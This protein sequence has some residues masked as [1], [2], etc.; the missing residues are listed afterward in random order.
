MCGIVGYIGKRKAWP[1]LFKGLER[2]EYR[3]YDSAG[4]ALLQNGAFSVYKKKGRVVEL[5]K[6][7]KNQ[8]QLSGG[9]GI[10][11]TRWATHGVPSDRNAH[12]HLSSGGDIVIVHNG[13]IENYLS[14]KKILVGKGYRFKSDTDTEVLA[15]LIE[16]IKKH[17]KV[18]IDEVVRLALAQVSGAYAILVLSK[19]EP[20]TMV[21]AK[22][23][24][25]VVIGIGKKEFFVASDA[26]P[27]IE[28]TKKVI[29]LEDGQMATIK[30]SKLLIKTIKN[31][32]IKNPYVHTL[33]TKIEELE[34]GGFPLF[35][36]KEIFEQ[37][38]S[39]ADT[40]RGRIVLDKG[41]VK[42][43]GLEK[44]EKQLRS[45]NR[46][47]ITAM[48]TA[49]FTGLIGEY[50]F[51]ELA[52]I[53]TKVEYGSEF[54]YREAAVDENT[55]LLAISQSGETKDTLNAIKE[56]KKKGMLTLGIVNVIGSS[57]AREVDAGIYNH[58]GPETAVASTKASTSQALLQI[59]LAIYLGRMRFA[60][61]LSK[62]KAKGILKEMQKL[63]ALA[64]MILKSAN[65]IKKLAKKYKNYNNFFFLGRK[66]NVAAAM[67]GALK[68]KECS[69]I[70]VE[71]M[72][73]TEL[74]HGPIS[75]IDKNFPTLIIA[76]I[77][78]MYEKNKSSI[79]EIK[80]RGGPV[81]AITSLG[82]KELENI[83]DDVIYIPKTLE[84]LTPI[85]AFIPMQLL[86][87]YIAVERGNDVD[88]PRN[89]A[90]SVTVE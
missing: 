20:G 52:G 50:A 70:H 15:N 14:I 7:T 21:V 8:N 51:E 54:A 11:H 23:G 83:T 32:T 90:K 41:N 78:S 37:P 53:P 29:Y 60:R 18:E 46:L 25:P 67:E 24:S 34:K 69:Y 66:Y 33:K 19:D 5:S 75:L 38:K 36:L 49:R 57:I 35:M 12:P 79:Q 30:N 80:A 47:T 42:F 88:K 10:A 72:N 28:H 9:V 85:L 62:S 84:M 1:V 56:A 81:I 13:I 74:K 43:G 4:I 73:S 68:L 64:E 63:P 39:L 40:M 16:D 2:L 45:I 65:N 44:F 58:V 86:A 6:F 48:G 82:N 17:T 76:P 89:L 55:G 87:Y 27:I 77:D 31:K 61:G 59:M 22:V 71:G 26:T 3:G